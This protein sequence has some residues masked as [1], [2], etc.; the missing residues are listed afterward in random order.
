MNKRDIY[1]IYFQIPTWERYWMNYYSQYNT[2]SKFT[3]NNELHRITTT[4]KIMIPVPLTA[5]FKFSVLY[6]PYK[7]SNMPKNIQLILK[8]ISIWF[9]VQHN[10]KWTYTLQASES[11]TLY[12]PSMESLMQAKLLPKAHP[13][14]SKAQQQPIS[15]GLLKLRDK[16]SL[17]SP[18]LIIMI[19]K[20]CEAIYSNNWNCQGPTHTI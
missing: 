10:L 9:C 18:V 3:N 8:N 12:T 4:I 7:Y 16:W 19:G 17:K 2:S 20:L 6:L 11:I 5:L 15:Q 13:T 14:L 1:Q